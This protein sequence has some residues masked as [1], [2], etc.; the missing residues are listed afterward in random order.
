MGFWEKSRR[1]FKC[2]CEYG[3]QSVRRLAHQTGVSKSSVHRL[4]QAMGRRN[5]YPES[6]L[7]ETEDGRQWLMR[8]VVATLYTFGLK[9][10]VGLDTMSEFF[11]RVHL[12]TQL[13]CSP[14]ALRG[15]MHALETALLETA[16]TWEQDGQAC[17]EVREIIGAVDETF[18]ERMLLVFMDLA[19]GY[20]VR[21]EVADDRTYATWKALVEE[22]LKGLGTGVLYMVSDRAKALIQ[23]A[24]KGL[25][26]LSMPDFFHVVHDIV[27]SYSLPMGQRLRQARQELTKAQEALARRQAQLPV[28]QDDPEAMAVV[29]ARQTEV[30][31]WEE[32]HTSNRSLME[33]LTHTQH[34]I[35]NADST[36]HTAAQV[37]S[38]LQAT[39]AAIEA[40]AQDHQ[41]PIRHAAMTKVRK[42]L[43]DL[44]AVV[45][46]WWAG[47]R[48]DVAHAA[49][50]PLW[51]QWAEAC[52][53]PRVYWEH[54]VAHTRCPRR[55]A[56]LRQAL[57]AIQGAFDQHALTPCLPPHA[58]QAW[59]AWATHRVS[60][61][62]RASSAVEGRNGCLAQL[63]HN[64]RGLPKRRYKV[65]T[66]LHNFDG[67]AADGTTPASRFFRRPFPDL[68]ET[69]LAHIEALPQPR[70]RK[71]QVGLCH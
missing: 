25:E 52:L 14:S 68:F 28:V 65:W 43:P 71:R 48:R 21:E 3:S 67:H 37:A 10:G 50:S 1:I 55:K 70:R 57:E 66:V 40:L 15:V 12:E 19:T 62:Q 26:C 6:W 54:Q 27:K 56:K 13:G 7:W 5:R 8:L 39:V 58:L 61:F 44:A 53:L 47:V 4:T 17:G 16:A 51:Q 33:T 69:V 49:L 30:V 22:R 63:H 46:F 18:L 60:A 36:P 24:E 2:L 41:L 34:P 59:H 32:A 29:A 11:A 35:R 38:H 20:L 9:R 45:D 31:R 64:Q 23:L 42:Q